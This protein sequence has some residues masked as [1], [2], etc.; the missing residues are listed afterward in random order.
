MLVYSLKLLNV[1]L[2]RYTAEPLYNGHHWEPKF[3]L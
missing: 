3:G 2:C 1:M